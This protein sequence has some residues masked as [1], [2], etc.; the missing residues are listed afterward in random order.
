MKV[1]AISGSQ[2]G[3]EKAGSY[4]LIERICRACGEDYE[5]VSLRG[6]KIGGCTAC[7]GCV[8]DNVCVLKDDAAEL[9]EKFVKA[10]AFVIGGPNF[11]NGWNANLHCLLE[12]LYQFRHQA[13]EELW[14]KLC[15]AVGVGGG[16]GGPVC[17][18]IETIMGYSFI[19]TVAKVSGRGAAACFTCGYGETCKVGVPHMLWGEGVKI[20]D[21][22]I[23][24]VEK[25][26]ELLK[27]ADEAGKLLG[28]RLKS[29]DRKAVAEK[30]MQAMMSR[31]K[32]AT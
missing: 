11:F 30:M 20:T 26:P 31:F 21:D 4:K 1:L 8:K 19:E 16:D 32:E 15:V 25:Q 7:L 18:Q 6:K 9:R 10:D 23:P 27:A 17:E 3:Q 29:H 22:M 24:D 13:N 14:G 5:I 28:Q 2:R 12:R